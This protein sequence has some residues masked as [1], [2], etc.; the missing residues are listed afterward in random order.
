MNPIQF[1]A[2]HFIQA[3]SFQ[4]ALLVARTD[5]E[6]FQLRGFR[7]GLEGQLVGMRLAKS[8]YD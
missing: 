2:V 5:G 1:E 8:L 4:H 6:I 3:R 7:I